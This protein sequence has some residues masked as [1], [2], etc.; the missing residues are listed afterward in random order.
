MVDAE[1]V[2][3]NIGIITEVGVNIIFAKPYHGQSKP[4][5]RLWRTVHE[6]FDKFEQTYIG[7]NT[8]TRPDE[9][10]I[11]QQKISN[12]LPVSADGAE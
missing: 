2:E 10:R 6:M 8:A 12:Y 4:I 11:Y 9:A 3:R 7:S 1:D 5:E